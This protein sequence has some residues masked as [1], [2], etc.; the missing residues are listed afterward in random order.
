M[1]KRKVFIAALLVAAAVSVA[2]VSCK[3]EKHETSSSN[4]TEQAVQSADNMDEY[5]ISFKKKLLSAQKGD[6]TI[7]IEQAQ[8][9]LGNLL[10]FDFGDANYATNVF[11]VDSI[12]AKLSVEESMVDLSQLALTYQM[13]FEQIMNDY[14]L[15]DLPEKS[16]YSIYCSFDDSNCKADSVDVLI[17]LTIRAYDEDL[18]NEEYTQEGW[19]ARNKAGTCDGQLVGVWGAP[20]DILARLRNNMGEWACANGGRVY[21][22]EETYSWIGANESSMIDANAP[23]GRR[24]FYMAEELSFIDLGLTCLDH[25]EMEYYYGQACILPSILGNS[26]HPAVPSNH[27]VTNYRYITFHNY[28]MGNVAYWRLDIAHAKL[29]CSGSQPVVD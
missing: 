13:L 27:V 1:K 26:F 18:N 28:D 8:Q 17:I 10:N 23:R 25:N 19:R 4:N 11:Y 3:K 2:V 29:N 16:V 6:E 22:T 24:L 20:E 14:F 9:D 21:F 7:S 15:V 12:Y 5:L